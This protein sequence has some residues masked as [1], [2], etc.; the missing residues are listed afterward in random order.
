M[1]IIFEAKKVLQV[2]HGL[3][4]PPVID[5]LLT[6]K[7]YLILGMRKMRMLRKLTSC[8]TAVAMWTKLYSKKCF[9]SSKDIFQ[10]IDSLEKRI[11]RYKSMIQS[12]G[13]NNIENDYAF[14]MQ[15][16]VVSLQPLNKKEQWQKDITYIKDLK[17]RSK[18]Y[19]CHDLGHW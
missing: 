12:Q 14:F 19:N 17:A 3:K 15:S 8:S 9:Q 4:K 5:P 10:T 2:V 18:C 11:F 6:T 16:T 13:R 1:E 7:F